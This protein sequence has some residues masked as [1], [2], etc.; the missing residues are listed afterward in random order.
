MAQRVLILQCPLKASQ[1]SLAQL[2]IQ[3]ELGFQVS[4]Q[5]LAILKSD[6]G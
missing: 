5:K 1:E 3:Q 2:D 6:P 4:A